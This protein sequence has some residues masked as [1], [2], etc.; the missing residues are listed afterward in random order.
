[1]I[2]IYIHIYIIKVKIKIVQI[3]YRNIPLVFACGSDTESF[4]YETFSDYS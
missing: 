2:Y 1:M 4:L 3:I